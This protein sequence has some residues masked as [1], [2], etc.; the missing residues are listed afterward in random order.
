M[1]SILTVNLFIG[2]ADEI[3]WDVLDINNWKT[4]TMALSMPTCWM[5]VEDSVGAMIFHVEPL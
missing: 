4:L 1:T 2:N 3:H 5:I